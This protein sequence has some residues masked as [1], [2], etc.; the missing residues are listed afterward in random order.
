MCQWFCAWT[1]EECWL[2]NRLDKK[3]VI[4]IQ[5]L[6][7]RPLF[8]SIGVDVQQKLIQCALSSKKHCSC[9]GASGG[10]SVTEVVPPQI[11]AV[12]DHVS[13]HDAARLPHARRCRHRQRPFGIRETRVCHRPDLHAMS[14][15]E[16]LSISYVKSA[17]RVIINMATRV[18]WDAAAYLSRQT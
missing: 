2:K 18:G 12:V 5:L 4:I 1:I 16:L 10:V 14:A 13:E 9:F 11:V 3:T 7:T 17:A 15:Q 8:R 6:H